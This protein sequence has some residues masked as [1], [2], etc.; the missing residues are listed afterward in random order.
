MSIFRIEKN[1]NYTAM[2]NYHFQDMNL[3]LKAIGLLSKMLSLPDNW[4]YSQAGLAKICKDGED[5]ISSALKELEKFGY[6]TRERERLHNGRMGGMIYHVYEVPK[7]LIS[8]NSPS[9]LVPE[10]K[11][12]S[13][14][15]HSP[16]PDYPRRENPVQVNPSQEIPKQ[17][18]PTQEAPKQENQTKKN[19]NIINNK[20]ESNNQKNTNSL[21]YSFNPSIR[22][23]RSITYSDKYT[24]EEYDEGYFENEYGE[25]EMIPAIDQIDRLIENKDNKKDYEIYNAVTDVVKQAVN[26]TYFKKKNKDADRR[27]SDENNP[28]SLEDYDKICKEHNLTK[29]NSIVRYIVDFVLNTDTRPVKIAHDLVPREIVKARILDTN[30]EKIKNVIIKLSED[31]IKNPKAYAIA[32]LYNS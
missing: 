23:E 3:S 20:A 1:K 2:S 9:S 26:Y 29:L 13:I 8:E 25:M 18:I 16:K 6:L 7:D 11:T 10:N 30:I 24:E 27:L 28:I 22:E 12:K 31:G 19:N 14:K 17:G 4:D 32:I 15:A 5:S 21:I